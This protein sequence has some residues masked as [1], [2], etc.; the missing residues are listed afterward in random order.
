M[1]G[2]ET[3]GSG[4]GLTGSSFGRLGSVI[5]CLLEKQ[6]GIN[7]ED[8]WPGYRALAAKNQAQPGPGA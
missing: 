7:G 5:D 2:L 4:A 8:G 6:Q 3:T 1:Y